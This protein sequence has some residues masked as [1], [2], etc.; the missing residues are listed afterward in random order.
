[1]FYV[2]AQLVKITCSCYDRAAVESCDSNVR[3]VLNT[4]TVRQ[5]GKTRENPSNFK[6]SIRDVYAYGILRSNPTNKGRVLP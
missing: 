4:A 5:E 1:M 2:D 3:C 6:G